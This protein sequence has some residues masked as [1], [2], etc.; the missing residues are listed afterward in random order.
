MWTN[1]TPGRDLAGPAW[2]VQGSPAAQP[3]PLPPVWLG[4]SPQPYAGE[5]T[6]QRGCGKC[7]GGRRAV[8]MVDGLGVYGVCV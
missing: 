5:C 8:V 4:P 7:G 2:G 3:A 6:K 1:A